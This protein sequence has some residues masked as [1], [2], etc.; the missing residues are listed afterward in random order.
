MSKTNTPS[1]FS[2]DT[3]LGWAL[4]T[5][6]RDYSKQ[7]E[8]ALA[9]LPG[10]ARAFMVMSLVEKETCHSQIVIADRLSVDKTTLTY[11]LDPLEQ[12]GLLKRITDPSDRRSRH[13][14]LTEAGA[15]ALA[16]YAKAVRQVEQSILSRLGDDEAASF[17]ASLLRVAG[18]RGSGHP[19]SPE[20][21]HMCQVA[22]ADTKAC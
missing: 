8:A 19:S 12:Q 21:V 13:I 20:D 7:V 10:G 1:E 9:G 6:L 3:N 16:K 18:L 4:A 14:N 2:L 15:K 11:L 17:H 22:L 5:V